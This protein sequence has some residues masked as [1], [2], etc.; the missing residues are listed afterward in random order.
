MDVVQTLVDEEG[1][2][3]DPEIALGVDLG[4]VQMEIVRAAHVVVV[5]ARMTGSHGSSDGTTSA[6][7]AEAVDAID[8][9]DVRIRSS[10][11]RGSRGSRMVQ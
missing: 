11:S 7:A 9:V 3:A 10:C 2:S 8:A 4:E 6:E 1:E 5:G